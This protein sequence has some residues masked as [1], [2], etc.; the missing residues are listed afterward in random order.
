MH[1]KKCSKILKSLS[2]LLLKRIL[3]RICLNEIP[4]TKV[5]HFLKC[6]NYVPWMRITRFNGIKRKI[7]WYWTRQTHFSLYSFFELFIKNIS[8]RFDNLLLDKHLRLAS[9]SDPQFKLWVRKKKAKKVTPSFSKRSSTTY[10]CRS[11]N[12]FIPEVYLYTK[13]LNNYGVG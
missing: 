12:Q 7:D 6:G 11:W 2:W 3:K 13:V 9:L 10:F 1:W 8:V 5:K 4:I